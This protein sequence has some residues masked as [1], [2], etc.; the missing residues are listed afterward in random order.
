MLLT[1]NFP[2]ALFVRSETA[3]QQGIDNSPPPE[4]VENLKM[5]AAGL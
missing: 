2:L 1:R 3:E 4:V 5:L